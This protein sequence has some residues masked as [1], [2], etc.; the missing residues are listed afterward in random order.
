MIVVE[1]TMDSEGLI[2][3]RE[4]Q[5]ELR[6]R[7]R[8]FIE[9]TIPISNELSHTQEGWEVV[10]RNK[11]T[12]RIRKPKPVGQQLEDEVWALLALTGFPEMSLGRNFT[13][14]VSGEEAEVP[15]KQIDVMAVDDETAL[16]VE[17]KASE[18]PRKRS[19]QKELN[20]TRACSSQLEIGSTPNTMTVVGFA[21]SM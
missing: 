7:R 19:L 13:I 12:L 15:P 4:I 1:P 14:P 21:S 3:G 18:G 20:E 16:V 8:A 10:R 2:S 9:I 5:T 6:S 11:N 17:C